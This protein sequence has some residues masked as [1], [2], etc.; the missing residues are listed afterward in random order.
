MYENTEEFQ[1]TTGRKTVQ[2]D[3]IF[4]ELHH[5]NFESGTFTDWHDNW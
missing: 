2:P 4:L 1:Q 3:S 5:A